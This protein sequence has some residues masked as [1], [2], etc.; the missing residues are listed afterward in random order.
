M[1]LLRDESSRVCKTGSGPLCTDVYKNVNWRMNYVARAM[2][3]LRAREC[4]MLFFLIFLIT[5]N[6]DFIVQVGIASG[7]SSQKSQ[8][9]NTVYL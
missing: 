3:G 6:C 8:A 7:S 2:I 4:A 1:C 5:F 9:N